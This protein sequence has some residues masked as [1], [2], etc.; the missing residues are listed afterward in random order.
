MSLLIRPALFL[1]ALA[2]I[3][4]GNAAPDVDTAPP[5]KGTV[6]VTLAAVSLGG[7]CP[8]E[9]VVHPEPPAPITPAQ[10]PVAAARAAMEP[11]RIALAQDI[12]PGWQPPCDQTTM[13]L[14]VANSTTGMANVAI[15]KVE[16]IDESGATLRELTARAPVRWASDR[17]TSWDQSVAPGQVLQVSYALSA[18]LANYGETYTL[19]VTVAT[20]AGEHTVEKLAVISAEATLPPAMVT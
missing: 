13:Q 17:Y 12:A 14:R 20:E 6:D 8:G 2:S 15:R 10:E 9:P 4:C 16:L 18:P 3:S 19:R 1:A 7:D 5:D 11:K